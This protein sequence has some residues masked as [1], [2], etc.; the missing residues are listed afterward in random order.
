MIT[1]R[2][3]YKQKQII[4]T[5]SFNYLIGIKIPST[6]SSI[7]PLPYPI[8]RDLNSNSSYGWALGFGRT[9]RDLS[10]QTTYGFDETTCFWAG[11]SGCSFMFDFY[12]G[13]YLFYGMPES[14][15]SSGT[16]DIKF[17]GT[18]NYSNEITENFLRKQ[19]AD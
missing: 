19:I 18:P 7:N 13:N 16:F 5:E 8:S 12:T 15:L 17:I 14:N 6:S 1:N 3:F 11:L 10:N 4:K 2:G 9:N